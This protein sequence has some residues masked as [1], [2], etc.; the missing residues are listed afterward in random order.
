MQKRTLTISRKDFIGEPFTECP[1]CH[2][3]T[4]G[5]FVTVSGGHSYDKE[6]TTCWHKESYKLPP[7]KKKIIYLDQFVID[8]IVKTLD[9]QH[10]KHAAVSQNPFWL[11]VFKKL[12]AVC[13]AEMVVCPDSFFH[14]EESG[15]TNYFKSMQ[16]IYEHFSGG[17]TF[18]NYTEITRFQ[19]CEHFGSYLEGHPEIEPKTEPNDIAHG[20]LHAWRGRIQIS[21]NMQP[22][23]QDVATTLGH[24]S[25]SYSQ[26]VSVF[27]RWQTETGKSFDDFYT[28]EMIGFAKG[29]REAIRQ[30]AERQATAPQKFLEQGDFDLNDILPPSSYE[31]IMSMKMTAAKHGFRDQEGMNKIAEYLF[32]DK[33]LE[34]LEKIPILRVGTL[35]YAALAH[36]A[37]NGRKKPP[38]PGVMVD[39]NMI[40]SL[41]PYCDAMFIDKENAALLEDGRVA[42]KLGCKTKIFSLRNKEEFLQHLDEII[43]TADPEHILFV[44]N[45]HG[46]DWQK[47]YLKILD[48][49]RLSATE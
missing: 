17:V 1:N 47:P 10:P 4:L 25:K 14:Q 6:C 32:S 22:K 2:K 48:H 38:S 37:A 3:N 31:L 11:E 19:I 23:P 34:N 12:E 16:R 29:T 5:V 41:L 30:F 49:E 40:S 33:N 15:P 43:Q 45:M 28:E 7:I 42:Q 20:D 26:F 9:S 39:V 36:Q 13:R 8:N 18:E 24:K 44:E 35:L 27:E 46:K 21:I